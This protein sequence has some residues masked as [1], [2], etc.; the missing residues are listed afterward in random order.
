MWCGGKKERKAL[1]SLMTSR[2]RLRLSFLPF[3]TALFA[4]PL[5]C[6]S[7][8]LELGIESSKHDPLLQ[9]DSFALSI[10]FDPSKVIQLTWHPRVFFYERF[11]TDEDCDHLITLAQGKLE[12][13][14]VDASK[15]NSTAS[16]LDISSGMF[17]PRGQDEVVSKIEERI[18]TWTF[19]KK[20]NG[21]NMLIMHSLANESYEPHYDYYHDESKLAVGGHRVAT[22]LMYLSNVSRGGETIFPQSKL[23]DTQTKDDTWSPCAATGYAVKPLRGSA[24]LYFNLHPDATPDEASLHGSCMVL[25]G[26][27]WTA[28]KWIHVRD[29]NPSKHSIVSEG[30]CTDED[31]NCPQWAAIGECK[32][33]PV[34]ML[35]T[36]DYYGSCRKSCGAC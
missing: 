7:R 18:S 8:E 22:V 34:Y 24:I 11:L 12:K 23:K 17:L 25:D 33:N 20:E 16:S 31:A 1:A 28:T 29:F 2:C 6:S 15:G 9:Q 10:H 30:E 14:V 32:R 3:L 36:P 21:E 35:G 13:L 4:C 19:L 26:E 5:P 27:R